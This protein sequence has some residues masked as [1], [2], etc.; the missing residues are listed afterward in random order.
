MSNGILLKCL[1]FTLLGFLGWD[2]GMR[3]LNDNDDVGT[4][5]SSRSSVPSNCETVDVLQV[6]RPPGKYVVHAYATNQQCV[7]V[8]EIEIKEGCQNSPIEFKDC[9]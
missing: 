9:N 2:F 8:Q 3:F 1:F 5:T 4:I 7:W 6:A